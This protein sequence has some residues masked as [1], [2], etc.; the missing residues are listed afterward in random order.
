M[1]RSP[2][3]KLRPRRDLNSLSFILNECIY[4]LNDLLLDL[5][6]FLV[7]PGFHL[8]RMQALVFKFVI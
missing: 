3:P 5:L 7:G 6:G 1:E 4:V 8:Q 2:A